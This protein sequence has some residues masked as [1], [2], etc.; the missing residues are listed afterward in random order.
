MPRRVPAIVRAAADG[1]RRSLFAVA[2]EQAT[3]ARRGFARGSELTVAHLEHIGES[4]LFGYNA[5]LAT[6]TAKDLSL[7]IRSVPAS[8]HGFAI[9]G[10]AMALAIL[11]RVAPWRRDRFARLLHSFPRHSYMIHIGAGLALARLNLAQFAPA[12]RRLLRRL[13]PLLGWLALDGWGF[14]EGYFHPRRILQRRRLPGATSYDARAFAQGL[15]RSLWFSQCADPARISA[16]IS[17]F[18]EVNRGDLWSG[19]GLAC[20]YAGGATDAAIIALRDL[21]WPHRAELAQGAAF[22]TKAR[23][24]AMILTEHTT[25]ACRILCGREVHEAAAITDECA[26][27][28]PANA[29]TPAFEWWRARIAGRL[30]QG[31]GKGEREHRHTDQLVH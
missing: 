31:E 10:A 26:R 7:R 12:R 4:F 27:D 24:R 17:R 14:H 20:T 18:P 6:G 19:V 28:L 15:G 2:V 29:A 11:D 22:A 8:H 25:R 1:I 3:F 13:D 21:G 5:A 23:L 9:E 30:G 16:T